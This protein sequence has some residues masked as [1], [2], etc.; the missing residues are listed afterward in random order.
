M[1]L[2]RT[3]LTH[4]RLSRLFSHSKLLWINFSFNFSL[5]SL[6]I[7]LTQKFSVF[8]F[9]LLSAIIQ[10]L[11]SLLLIF[12]CTISSHKH[13]KKKSRRKKMCGL[14]WWHW[15]CRDGE[16]DWISWGG[17]LS[18]FLVIWFW[19]FYKNEEEKFNENVERDEID[20]LSMRPREKDIAIWTRI[21]E[22]F[23]NLL[24]SY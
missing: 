23:K 18:Q 5:H 13:N 7:L 12:L 15:W 4:S 17:K 3:F 21:F 20:D 9:N 6:L 19:F 24:G 10:S 16:N 14:I 8:L 1:C 22:F 2:L 11:N